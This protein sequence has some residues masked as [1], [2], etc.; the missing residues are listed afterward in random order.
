MWILSLSLSSLFPRFFLYYTVRFSPVPHTHTH[1]HNPTPM[2]L[3]QRAN[4]SSKLS[5]PPEEGEAAMKKAP[6]ALPAALALPMLALATL[7]LAFTAV[8]SGLAGKG[9]PFLKASSPLADLLA[10]MGGSWEKV[11][12]RRGGGK[13]GF[14]YGGGAFV[15]TPRRCRLCLAFPRI[16]SG[17]CGLDMEGV[18]CG[19][20]ESDEG[21]AGAP[22][23]FFLND[24]KQMRAARRPA[25]RLSPLSLSRALSPAP[26]HPPPTP[27][28]RLR[29]TSPP[30]TPSTPP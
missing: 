10:V 17:L 25:F 9:V 28:P 14:S 12:Q 5:P 1:T 18:F 19:G 2:A 7:A 6:T 26:P 3:R 13:R 11:R 29:S 8:S 24:K 21:K 23:T 22:A 30:T 15:P 27:L 16:V 4:P 20:L